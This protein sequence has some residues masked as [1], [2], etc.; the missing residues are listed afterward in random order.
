MPELP[1]VQT[2]VSDLEKKILGA[3]IVESWIDWPKMIKNPVKQS[4]TTVSV[5]ALADFQKNIIGKRVLAVE[6]VAKNILIHLS[7]EYT[8]LIHQK[9]TGHILIGQWELGQKRAKP[10]SPKEIVEDPFNGYVHF[11]LRLDDGR[12]VGISDVR[13]FAK[14]LFAKTEII[15]ALPELV[16][17]G[18]DA[19]SLGLKKKEMV[20]IL[21]KQKRKIKTVLLD[22]K[23]VAGIGNIYSDDILWDAKVH[24]ER[25]AAELSLEERGRIYASMRRILK[26]AVRLR[27][28][29]TTDFRDTDGKRGGYAKELL[30]YQRDG[31][32]CFQCQTLIKKTVVGGRSARFCQQCQPRR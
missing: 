3:T 23:V 26:K 6:R 31:E 30:V 5:K 16:Q 4:K 8:L 19:L 28:T 24:P 10:L 12:M 13:K 9:M 15:R 21:G 18:P 2:V 7:E 27:G 32:P 17:L 29:S 11:V 25:R 20:E 14:V 1:E 22:P